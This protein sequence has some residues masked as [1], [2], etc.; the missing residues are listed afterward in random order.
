MYLGNCVNH[1]LLLNDF[2]NRFS[3]FKIVAIDVSKSC[4]MYSVIR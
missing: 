2:L 1:D 4:I 3:S